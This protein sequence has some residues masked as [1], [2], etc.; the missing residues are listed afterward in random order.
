MANDDTPSISGFEM[1]S[2]MLTGKTGSSDDDGR[3]MNVN[4]PPVV[5]PDDIK[6][7]LDV[8]QDDTDDDDIDKDDNK[9][10]DDIS[11][12][13]DDDTGD[14]SG[15]DSDSSDQVDDKPDSDDS[16]DDSGDIDKEVEL[17]EYELD[18]TSFLNERLAE[19]IGW[20]IPEDEAPK[21][22]GELVEFMRDIV[23]EASTP[24][25]ANDEVEAFD[26]YVREGG[27]LRKFYQSAVEG[28]IDIDSVDIE[29]S[30]DQKRVLTEHYKNQGYGEDRINR[31]LK[32]WEDAGV[33]DEE[34]KD[35]LELLK[36]YNEKNRK[37][38]LEQQEK[39]A[40]QAEQQQQKFVSTVEQSIKELKDIRGFTIPEKEKQELLEYILMPDS[41]GI[42]QY[43]R[44]YMSDIKN[45]IESAYF[46][47]KGDVLLSRSAKKG[48]TNAVKNLRDK[49][50][51][52]KGD[53]GKQSGAQDR[54]KASSGLGVLGSML[55]G[56]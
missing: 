15:S 44:D 6:K 30:F 43:Q 20:N 24:K 27:D 18:I 48:Q 54:G 34:A 50:D 45:L 56:S 13:S 8:D 25:Y 10:T 17:G 36:D 9:D 53:K 55:Q 29:S 12:D 35:A 26:K 7:N 32:R 37:T 38:L 49:L 47:K 40:K 3:K 21:T 28:R 5:D 23:Q 33:L 41:E 51:A 11:P 39:V 4:E 52:N 19:E 1:I 22:V 46:T 16:K 14:D 2:S 31:M 42:T